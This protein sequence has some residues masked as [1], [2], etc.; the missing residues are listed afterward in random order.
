MTTHDQ[1]Y[2][3]L[4]QAAAWVVYRENKLV[5]HM[6]SPEAGAFGAIGMY[7]TMGPKNRKALGKLQE[8]HNALASGRLIARGYR[9]SAEHILADIPK[10]EW[11]SLHLAPPHAYDVSRLAQKIEPWRSIQ[12]DAADVKKLWRSDLEVKGR[13]KYDH[14]LIRSLYDTAKAVN[15]EMS[16]NELIGE[17][18]KAYAEQTNRDEPGRSTVQRAIK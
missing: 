13:S 2:W 6:N 4:A 15:P 8:L 16:Q 11:A 9:T 1:Q 10:R 5:E 14:E 12:V 17:I 18:Q 7:P 3:N